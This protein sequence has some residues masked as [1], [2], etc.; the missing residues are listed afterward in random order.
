[1]KYW[2]G[3]L[4]AAIFAAITWALTS[5]A[6]RHG[7]LV[8]MVYPYLTRVIQTTLAEWTA[9]ADYL[10]WQLLMIGGMLLISLE[11]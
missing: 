5:F 10:L 8:D 3:Y 9:G 11:T 4:T 1:M 7:A 6:E 2:R